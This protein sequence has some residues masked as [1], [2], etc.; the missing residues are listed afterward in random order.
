[1]FPIRQLELSSCQ[2][3]LSSLVSSPPCTRIST[4]SDSST[5]TRP[6]PPYVPQF[7][8]PDKNPV[9]RAK[10]NLLAFQFD[11][12]IIPPWVQLAQYSAGDDQ[13]IQAFL[14]MAILTS[15]GTLSSKEVEITELDD[16]QELLRRLAEGV[17]SSEEVAVAVSAFRHILED[18]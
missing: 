1:M 8:L 6:P 11:N 7:S 3:Q 16:V 10:A 12:N 2:N 4:V 15:C 9:T 5:R 18:V 14:D 17:W 13:S